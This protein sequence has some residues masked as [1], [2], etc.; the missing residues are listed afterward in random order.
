MFDG[1]VVSRVSEERSV[2]ICCRIL[3]EDI[4][5]SDM[6]HYQAAGRGVV[7]V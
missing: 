6:H 4:H 7:N 3:F 5:E 2:K 1:S